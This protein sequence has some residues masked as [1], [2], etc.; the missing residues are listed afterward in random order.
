MKCLPRLLPSLAQ[1]LT[2]EGRP[3][4]RPS[5]RGPLLGI[6]ALALS[7]S[8]SA[9][10]DW[11]MWGGSAARNLVAGG[12]AS[13]PA[14]FDPDTG[15]NLRWSVELG[16]Q[17]F[18]SPVV[19]GGRVFI[20]TNNQT[21][22]N[23]DLTGDRGIL[24]AFNA[25]DGQFLWQLAVPKL[26]DRVNDWPFIGVT[27]SPAIVGD[28][29][30]VVTNRCEVVCF[31]VA[32]MADG[33]Q[34]MQEEDVYIAGEMDAFLDDPGSVDRGALYQPGA[35]DAD[36]LWVYDMRRE[37]GVHPHC[38]S[39][40]SVLAADGKIYV[41]TSNGVDESHINLPAPNVPSLI[42]LDPAT[43]ALLGEQ[44]PLGDVPANEGNKLFHGTWSSPAFAEIGGRPQIIFGGGNGWLYGLSPDGAPGGGGINLL[45]EFWRYDANPPEYRKDSQAIGSLFC[46]VGM[47]RAGSSRRRSP[48]TAWFT[49]RSGRTRS[50]AKASACSVVSTRQ[51][52]ATSAATRSGRSKKSA[53][54]SPP[55]RSPAACST[56][57]TTAASSIASMPRPARSIGNTICS[58]PP[59]DRPRR[60][61]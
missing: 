31:D 35:A 40:C 24:M 55:R 53:A 60:R 6:L 4:G 47:V 15:T 1:R 25:A 16:S 43:G 2:R 33:N 18:A 7:V 49:R 36:I 34:G 58:P 20:G 48:T 28:R 12:D 30:F 5:H 19:A 13:P 52:M 50:T 32:G 9:A 38:T 11:S 42:C 57:P 27:S 37:I 21:P 14:E 10:A 59:G 56:S 45:N 54:R 26:P 22:R 61:R 23:E 17:T 39:N 46:L 44:E 3:S 29:G 41:A 8:V 51:E